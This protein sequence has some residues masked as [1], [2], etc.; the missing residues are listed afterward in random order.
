MKNRHSLPLIG[1][2]LNQ[3]SKA[4]Y[5]TK[6]DIISAFNKLRIK[7]G[8]EWKAAFTC[9]YG[10][11]EPLVLPF[12]LSNG[13]VSFQ[14][15]IN[16]ALHGLLDRFCTAYM[17]DILIYSDNLTDYRRYVR[18]VLQRLRE[19]GLQA[20][21]SKCN[22]ET[23][24]ITYLGLIVSTKEISMDPKKVACVQE[25]PTPRCLHATLTQAITMHFL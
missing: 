4:R 18:E 3:L 24:Q 21:I 14:S 10:L 13:P 20:D 8:D 15:Y 17:D 16:H 6:L 12:G 23:T 5:F 25:W 19:N 1:E 22:F 7:E 11:F 2:T 9:R